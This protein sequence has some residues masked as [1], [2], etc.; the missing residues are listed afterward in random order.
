[1]TIK[2][3]D[4]MKKSLILLVLSILA[5]CIPAQAEHLKFMGIPL[6]GTITQFQQKLAAKGVTHDKKAS[7]VAAVG[8]RIFTGKFAGSKADIVV[9]YDAD[10]KIVYGAKAVYEFYSTTTRDN[11]YNDLKDMLSTK[12]SEETCEESYQDG[13]D[14]YLVKVT[15]DY[16]YSILGAISLYCSKGEFPY[17]D[18]YYVHVEYLDFENYSKNQDSKMNDL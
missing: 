4:N 8:T 12:Y 14:A 5:I 15:D 9:W 6:T 17:D 1:M 3:K 16:G 10:T 18:T 7:A 13:H 11:K 2:E